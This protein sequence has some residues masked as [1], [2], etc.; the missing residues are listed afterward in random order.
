[1]RVV[2][3]STPAPAELRGA[4]LALGN[5][6]GV[7]L[8]H[9]HVVQGAIA[10]ASSNGLTLA[11][12]VFEPHPR[13]HFF[14]NGPPFRL[15][16]PGQ[17]ARALAALGVEVIFEIAFDASVAALTDEEFVRTILAERLGAAHVAVGAD[18]YFG[19]GRM[20]DAA[21]LTTHAASHGISVSVANVLGGETKISSSTIREEL[22][23]G[24]MQDAAALLTRP[25]AIEGIVMPGDARGRTI[26][27]PTLN[28]ALGVYKRPRQGVYAVRVNIGDGAWRPG[29]A[30]YGVRPSVGGSE[31]RLET[32]LFDYEG[33]LYGRRIEV[34][35]IAFL[36]D[37]QKFDG[38]D[39]LKAQ[40][41]IDA[42]AARAALL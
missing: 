2:A 26:G 34:A 42:V 30:N 14:P 39:A 20:G 40:I 41:A 29:V 18:F 1:M 12:A 33:D 37:E 25:W 36:R 11:A 38:L 28:M 5:F 19:R 31:P 10:N 21:S 7:H 16:S 23:E 27:F 15:Q 8:G 6:D 22:T 9:Q 17:R 35:L 13:Q 4:V 24:R 32:H 3:S